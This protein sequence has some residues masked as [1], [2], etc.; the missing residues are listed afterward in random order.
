MKNHKKKTLSTLDLIDPYELIPSSSSADVTFNLTSIN[1]TGLFCPE[2]IFLCCT[3]SLFMTPDP[4]L[5]KL[6]L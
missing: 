2:R 1:H 4:E 5:Q 3:C 6:N